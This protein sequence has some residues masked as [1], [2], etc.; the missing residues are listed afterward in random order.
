MEAI[1]LVVQ[2]I[3]AIVIFVVSRHAVCKI[4][5]TGSTKTE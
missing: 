5:K 4:E 3:A 1:G 2:I